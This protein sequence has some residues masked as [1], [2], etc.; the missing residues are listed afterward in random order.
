MIDFSA[1]E[2]VIVGLI[3]YIE[4]GK[5]F[6]RET[7]DPRY[8]LENRYELTVFPTKD[9]YI[10]LSKTSDGFY[11]FEATPDNSTYPRLTSEI[12]MGSEDKLYPLMDL[13]WQHVSYLSTP[14]SDDFKKEHLVKL[15]ENL[16]EKI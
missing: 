6:S 10:Q 13:L 16:M 15:I 12:L 8:P 2:D 4:S 7:F 1:L 3:K 5:L 14:L 9:V 11:R